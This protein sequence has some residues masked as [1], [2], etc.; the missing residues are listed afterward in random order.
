[1][2]L[3]ECGCGGQTNVAPQ[4]IIKRGM[5]K[6]ESF[7]FIQGHGRWQNR[8]EPTPK[9]Y[10]T[11]KREGKTKAQHL[12]IAERALGY[13]L[14]T[15][16]EV[17]H[18][19]EDSRDNSRLVICQDS[20]YHKFLHVRTRTVKAGGDPNT[21]K[22]CKGCGVVR[23]FTDFYRSKFVKATGLTPRCRYCILEWQKNRRIQR[24]EAAR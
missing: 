2:R 14:P 19:G 8:S 13:S 5:Q 22:F 1:M 3:C 9:G 15:G 12:L 18:S 21:Q 24:I 20:E 11:A 16:V 4:P 7:R 23:L 17:H 6:G 10:W